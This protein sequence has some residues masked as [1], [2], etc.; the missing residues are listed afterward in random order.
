MELVSGPDVGGGFLFQLTVDG[1]ELNSV[2]TFH[3]QEGGIDGGEG[4]AGSPQALGF[5]VP[6][7]MCPIGGRICWHREFEVPTLEA[8]KVRFAYNRLRFVI[9]PTL[10]QKS[11]EVPVPFDAGVRETLRHIV[12]PLTE[13]KVPWFVGGSSAPTLLGAKLDPRDLDLGTTGAGVR[14][15]GDALAPYIVEPVALTRMS[16]GGRRWA[17]RAFVGTFQDGLLVEWAEL[18][19]PSPASGPLHEWSTEVLE[20]AEPCS[21]DEWQVLVAPPE[22]ALV[23]ALTARREP[24]IREILP[25]VQARPVHRSLLD[26]LLPDQGPTAGLRQALATRLSGGSAQSGAAPASPRTGS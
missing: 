26:R 6:D 5:A 1:G 9:G 19:G 2:F 18:P 15:I 10:R 25:L 20:A 11:G 13:A 8:L 12:A 23:K 14:I 7:R 21:V 3:A 4:T 22:V 16:D 17:G 24:R